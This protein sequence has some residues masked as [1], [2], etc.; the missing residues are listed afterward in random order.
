[1]TL[2]GGCSTPE[3]LADPAPPLPV[4]PLDAPAAAPL[5]VV[6]CCPEAVPDD[7]AGPVLLELDCCSAWLAPL[8]ALVEDSAAAASGGSDTPRSGLTSFRTP[9]G[10]TYKKKHS[11]MNRVL[12][13]VRWCRVCFFFSSGF[14]SLEARRRHFPK[15]HRGKTGFSRVRVYK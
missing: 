3:P 1:M 14:Q 7:A 6:C 11:F 5:A 9:S 15:H 10:P 8:V 4:A 2:G 13:G 12:Q